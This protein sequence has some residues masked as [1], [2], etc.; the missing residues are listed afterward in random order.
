MNDKTI[1]LIELKYDLE[2]FDYTHMMSDDHRVWSIGVHKEKELRGKIQ[3]FIKQYP[4]SV[5]ELKDIVIKYKQEYG[6]QFL[7]EFEK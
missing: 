2:N 3:N 6:T 7:V 4:N 1:D 5:D